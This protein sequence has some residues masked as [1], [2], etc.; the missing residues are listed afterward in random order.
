M[1]NYNNMYKG[2]RYIPNREEMNKEFSGLISL[3][4][5]DT[6]YCPGLTVDKI[7]ATEKFNRKCRVQA[8]KDKLQK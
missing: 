8:K 3:N 5:F 2:Y 7:I 1:I 4:D 6:S